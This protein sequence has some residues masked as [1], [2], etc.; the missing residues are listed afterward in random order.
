M[1]RKRE[2][3][4]TL[5]SDRKASK[6]ESVRRGCWWLRQRPVR[7]LRWGFAS[8]EGFE[9]LPSPPCFASENRIHKEQ[10]RRKG[11]VVRNVKGRGICAK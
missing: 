6:S 10:R 8:P 1:K 9:S 4:R 5:H 3:Q 7:R 2:S 11:E